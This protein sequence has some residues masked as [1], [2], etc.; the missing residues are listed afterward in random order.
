MEES[1]AENKVGKCA[2]FENATPQDGEDC[3]ELI[4]G[5]HFLTDFLTLIDGH[6][7]LKYVCR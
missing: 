2:A 6:F 7:T 1:E 5:V 3:V 4:M